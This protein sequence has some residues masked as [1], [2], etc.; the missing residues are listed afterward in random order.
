L[1]T[2]NKIIKKNK[3]KRVEETVIYTL[4]ESFQKNNNKMTTQDILNVMG[5]DLSFF[6][7]Y[8]TRDILKQLARRT[9]NT[10]ELRSEFIGIKI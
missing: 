9:G 4:L 7:K 1:K 10:W 5:T 3:I 6:D 2:Q 8:L